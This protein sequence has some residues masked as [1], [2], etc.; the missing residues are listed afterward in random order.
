MSQSASVMVKSSARVLKIS[1]AAAA[2][3]ALMGI[4]VHA[5]SGRPDSRT[6]TCGQVQS[7]INQ[8]GAVVLSTGQYTFDRYVTN[9]NSCF[10]GQFTRSA[11]IPTQDTQQ[12]RVLRCSNQ[13]QRLFAD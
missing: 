9:A 11:Y 6:M 4:P 13:Q 10:R 8:Q 5:Q 12:C 1:T 7:L 2:M 3:L